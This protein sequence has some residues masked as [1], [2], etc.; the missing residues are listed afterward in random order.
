MPIVYTA[1]GLVLSGH[2]AK[3]HLTARLWDGN[4]VQRNDGLKPTAPYNPRELRCLEFQGKLHLVKF[5]KVRISEYSSVA[6]LRGEVVNPKGYVIEK[7]LRRN[8][9]FN[10]IHSWEA[11]ERK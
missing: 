3:F 8:E 9:L 11:P 5:E 10:G 1:L 7:L 4:A 6:Q 2:V